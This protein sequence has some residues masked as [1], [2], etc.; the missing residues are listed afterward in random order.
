MCDWRRSCTK[1]STE[2][3]VIFLS[4]MLFFYMNYGILCAVHMHAVSVGGKDCTMP[5]SRNM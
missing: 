4:H 5:L 1:S 3:C 2:N